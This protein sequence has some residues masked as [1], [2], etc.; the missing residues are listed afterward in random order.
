M[1]Y[2]TDHFLGRQRNGLNHVSMNLAGF[3]RN[4]GP[5]QGTN[6]PVYSDQLLNW[7]QLKR[8]ES[9]RLLFTWEAV[10]STLGGPVPSP[11]AGYATYW[12]DL[13]DVVERLLARGIYV[14]IGPWQY[15]ANVADTDIAYDSAA[16]T[17]AEFSDFWGKFAAAFNAVTANDQRVAFDLINKRRG[18]R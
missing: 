2:P 7:Y 12:A 10:Q 4:N 17:S 8:V 1:P 6:Y 18:R 9:V 15:N 16:F 14:I 3:N 5:V 11:D 13:V